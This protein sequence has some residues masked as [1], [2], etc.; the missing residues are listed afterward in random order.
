MYRWAVNADENSIVIFNHIMSV[1]FQKVMQ[2][3]A[4]K[5]SSL[6][7]LLLLTK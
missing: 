4:L 1:T 6:K 7:F 5:I 2:N 3:G